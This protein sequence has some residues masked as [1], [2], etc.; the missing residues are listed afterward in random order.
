[1]DAAIDGEGGGHGAA[2]M[3]LGGAKMV[4]QIL[5]LGGGIQ[6]PATIG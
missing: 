3:K 5:Q 1:V 6:I 2:G 4:F